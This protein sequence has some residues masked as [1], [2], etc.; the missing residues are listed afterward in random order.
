MK[1]NIRFI[2]EAINVYRTSQFIVVQN[3]G[4]MLDD[5]EDNTMFSFD[6]YYTRNKKRDREYEQVFKNRKHI[7]GKRIRTTM[8]ARTYVN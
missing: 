8:Y 1:D 2:E 6:T 3:I 5:L 4:I 7:D